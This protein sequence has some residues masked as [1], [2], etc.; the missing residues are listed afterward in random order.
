M[1]I[2]SLSWHLNLKHPPNIITGHHRDH[3]ILSWSNSST[4]TSPPEDALAPAAAPLRFALAA[5]AFQSCPK[6]LCS[7]RLTIRYS[8]FLP[9]SSVGIDRNSTLN[10]SAFT[11]L[12]ILFWITH[13]STAF[14]IKPDF[15]GSIN[16][17]FYSFRAQINFLIYPRKAKMWIFAFQFSYQTPLFLKLFSKVDLVQRYLRSFEYLTPIR[18]FY[19]SIG[20][21][22]LFHR[23]AWATTIFRSIFF[24]H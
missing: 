8:S 21:L 19:I 10:G 3:R 23:E 9:E 17:F 13:L 22:S 24:Q 11:L 15:R 14:T 12:T 1:F 18:F 6:P 5:T 20:V 7:H 2:I 4:S 16:S